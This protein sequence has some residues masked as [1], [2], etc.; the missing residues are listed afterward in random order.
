MYIPK[1]F[2]VGKEYDAADVGFG[3]IKIIRRTEKTIWVTNGCSTW[4]MRI[5]H[6][7]CGDE[8]AID[9]A[10]PGRWR[11]AMTYRA[12]WIIPER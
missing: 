6:T 4:I 1:R 10:I 9:S 11:E 12:E 2:E 7:I 5:R 8:Y 3:P